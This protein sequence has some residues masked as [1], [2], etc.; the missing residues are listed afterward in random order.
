[1]EWVI[2]QLNAEIEELAATA[3]GT[4][5]APMAAAVTEKWHTL[6]VLFLLVPSKL[7]C[8]SIQPVLRWAALVLLV[9]C[10][11]RAAHFAIYILSIQWDDS[12]FRI[13]WMWRAQE[14]WKHY[15]SLCAQ[16]LTLK[17]P[18]MEEKCQSWDG[19][20]FRSHV[21]LKKKKKLFLNTADCT[22]T[23]LGR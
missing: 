1:M 23:N 7:H 9:F 3:R 2:R 16:S 15:L 21:L 20:T 22:H 10:I 11:T 6:P 5:R 4:L 13:K 8:L 12:D 14:R 17:A 18:D 19:C